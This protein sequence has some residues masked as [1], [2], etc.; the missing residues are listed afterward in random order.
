MKIIKDKDNLCLKCKY[1]IGI[2]YNQKIQR[3]GYEY[4]R[5]DCELMDSKN[6]GHRKTCKCF[7]PNEISEERK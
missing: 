5:C 2:Y 1:A 4:T 6:V 3:R 7:E